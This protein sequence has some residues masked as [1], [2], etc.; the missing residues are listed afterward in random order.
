QRKPWDRS[1]T[2]QYSETAGWREPWRT[3]HCG[4]R[5]RDGRGRG[6]PVLIDL[7]Q[8]GR[9]PLPSALHKNASARPAVFSSEAKAGSGGLTIRLFPES[10]GSAT[11]VNRTIILHFT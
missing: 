9:K 8:S 10:T 11:P 4:R 1:W 2:R 3:Y 7:R 5:F 6:F